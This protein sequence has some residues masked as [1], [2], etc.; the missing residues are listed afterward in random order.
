VLGRDPAPQVLL[1]FEAG[2]DRLFE[3]APP[4][5]EA[6]VRFAVR[7]PWSLPL[8][9][10][11]SG[12]VAPDS[13]LR[14]KL[15]LMLAVLETDP[16]HQGAFDPVPAAAPRLAARLAAEAARFA[17]KVALGLPVLALARSR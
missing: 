1:R 16:T 10:A 6:V 4:E 14:R 15:L 13:L 2:C 11:A 9:D 3:T 5:E 7:N 17:A 8:L 12:V